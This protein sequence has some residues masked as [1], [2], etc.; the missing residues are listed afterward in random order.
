[1]TSVMKHLRI[2]ITIIF[3]ALFSLT[4]TKSAHAQEASRGFLDTQLSAIAGSI[5]GIPANSK[6]G[7][8]IC[9]PNM[10]Q[11]KYIIGCDP[12]EDGTQAVTGMIPTL[13]EYIAIALTSPPISSREYIA[14][15]GSSIGLPTIQTANAQGVGY[16]FLKPV[17]ELW[18][19]FRN[20]AYT[21]YIIVFIVIGVMIMLRT[22]INAQTIITIQSA[23]PN[24]IITL[25]LI[26]FSYA[27]A[28]FFIDL[29]YFFIYFVVFLASNAGLIT[30][31]NTTVKTLTDGNI[32]QT[33]MLGKGNI[34]SVGSDAVKSTVTNILGDNLAGIS[35]GFLSKP[36]AWIVLAV[37][38]AAALFKTLL[39]LMKSYINIILLTITAPLVILANAI[40]GSKSFSSWIRR[41]AANAAPFPVVAAMLLFGA[42]LIGPATPSVIDGN[43]NPLNVTKNSGIGLSDSPDFKLP[44][45]LNF[46][47]VENEAGS[48]IS[49]SEAFLAFI[50]IGIILMIP[51]SAEMARDALKVEKVKYVSGISEALGAGA[52][53][54]AWP[55]RTGF[56]AYRR[57]RDARQQSELLGKA[58]RPPGFDRD[59]SP[60]G[61][62]A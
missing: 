26:T 28:G 1:M 5:T 50:G 46:V 29:M 42:I 53:A 58:I 4:T 59:D 49:P 16:D 19:A 55:F 61:S 23:I 60:P 47:G 8:T 44:P 37:A 6:L 41:L 9:S 10:S 27:I 39:E 40:P 12:S 17:L 33:M 51:K 2:T 7:Q 38:V 25:I 24:L 52:G 48:P 54:A 62:G 21:L 45:F 18:K 11:E 13:G 36:I 34:V 43:K 57:Q 22:K 20:L 56:G 15:L 30:S 32:F 14:D 35:V 31:P 3:L